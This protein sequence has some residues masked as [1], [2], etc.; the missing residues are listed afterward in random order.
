MER[1]TQQEMGLWP[2]GHG[3]LA[4]GTWGHPDL[5]PWHPLLS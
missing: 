4:E 5:A 3:P 2:G 1:T